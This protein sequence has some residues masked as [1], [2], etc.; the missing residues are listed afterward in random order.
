MRRW[1]GFFLLTLLVLGAPAAVRPASA[2]A[3]APQRLA[4]FESFDYAT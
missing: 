4:I 2:D 3:A 1:M